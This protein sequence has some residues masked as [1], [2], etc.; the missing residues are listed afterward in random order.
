MK[1]FITRALGFVGN[2][3]A[4]KLTTDHEVI[5]LSGSEATDNNIKQTGATPVRGELVKIE[6]PYPYLSTIIRS[7]A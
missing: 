1:F 7:Q 6:P 3:V 2:A 4:K 5:E